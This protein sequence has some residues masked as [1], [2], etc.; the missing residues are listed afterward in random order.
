MFRDSQ[1]VMDR[2]K[3]Y[4]QGQARIINLINIYRVLSTADIVSIS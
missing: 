2:D 4:G 1:W 3:G